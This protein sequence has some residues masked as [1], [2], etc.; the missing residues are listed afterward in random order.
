MFGL[1]KYKNSLGK[2]CEGIH[3]FRLF[4]IAIMDVLFTILGAFIIHLAVPNFKFEHV[5]LVL[6]LLGIVLHHLF[7]VRTTIDKW[8]FPN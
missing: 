8:L 5:L 7:C 1:C 4:N 6:F 2:P 3:R